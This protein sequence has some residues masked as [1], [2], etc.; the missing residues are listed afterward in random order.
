MFKQACCAAAIL[1][2]AMFSG[3]STASAQ[4]VDWFGGGVLTQVTDCPAGNIA[5]VTNRAFHARYRHPGLPGNGDDAL[6]SMFFNNWAFNFR[7]VGG[8]LPPTFEVVNGTFIGG[9]SGTYKPRLRILDHD[10][11]PETID[12]NTPAITLEGIIKK[13]SGFPGNENCVVRFITTMFR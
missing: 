2:A 11:A 6:L 3:V 12:Q 5:A 10:P 13:F 4:F 7:R 8:P 9:G 1:L